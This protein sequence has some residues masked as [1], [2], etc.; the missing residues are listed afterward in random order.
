MYQIYFLSIVINLIAGIVLSREI[1]TGKLPALANFIGDIEETSLFRL[2]GGIAAVA[3]GVLKLL[4]VTAGDV[5]IF[6]D[7]LPALAGIVTGATLLS[8]YFR[9]KVS[10][11]LPSWAARTADF[12]VAHKQIWGIIAI[13]AA[14]LHFFFYPALFL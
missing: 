3:V 4:L 2:A 13:V 12:L 10:A 14:I 5:R 9:E 8:G 6:G 11:G 1:I 7:F